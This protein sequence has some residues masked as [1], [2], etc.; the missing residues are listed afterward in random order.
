MYTYSRID[1][2]YIRAVPKYNYKRIYRDIVCSIIG[3]HA[4]LVIGYGRTW[5]S[6]SAVFL[7][8]VSFAWEMMTRTAST[9]LPVQYVLA[10]T[11]VVLSNDVWTRA[12]LSFIMACITLE[13]SAWFQE[14]MSRLNGYEVYAPLPQPEPETDTDE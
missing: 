11:A 1:D 5:L 4:V 8:Y 13:A 3:I 9:P 2:F 7:R 10:T 12:S 14:H 6:N